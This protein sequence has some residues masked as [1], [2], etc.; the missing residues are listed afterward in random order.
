MRASH[1]YTVA[2]PQDTYANTNMQ[3]LCDVCEGVSSVHPCAL[4]VLLF[5]MCVKEFHL[6]IHVHLMCCFL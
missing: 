4:N 1:A 5:V 2:Q 3:A 6:Y